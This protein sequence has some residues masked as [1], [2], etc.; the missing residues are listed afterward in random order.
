[1]PFGFGVLD[2]VNYNGDSCDCYFNIFMDPMFVDTTNGDLHLLAGSPCVDAGDPIYPYDPDSTIADQGC[3]FFDQRM[4]SIALSAAA[5]NFGGVT[6]GQ[7]ADL[8]FVI[9]NL[10][11]GNLRIFNIFNNMLDGPQTGCG[12]RYLQ[13]KRLKNRHGENFITQCWKNKQTGSG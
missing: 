3:Y 4:P 11:E 5:L 7:S 8:G 2:T 10:G 12:H 13:R 1:M 9:Y 6:V